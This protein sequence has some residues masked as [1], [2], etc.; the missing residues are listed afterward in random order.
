[1][2]LKT[3]LWLFGFL[4]LGLCGFSQ[5][6]CSKERYDLLMRQAD[7]LANKEAYS[8]AIRKY[9]SARACQPQYADIVDLRIS[10]VF[11]KVDSLRKKAEDLGEKL[12][13]EQKITK[14]ALERAKKLVAF[15]QFGK[16]KAAFAYDP[17]SGN[18]RVIDKQ[19]EELSKPI[20][21]HPSV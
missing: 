2:K 1:M 5:P 16:E 20:Y 12:T 21:Q 18:F 19:G 8:Q 11:A 9:T 17:E 13:K 15:F 3:S 7:S 14:Q 4:L 6:R 10:E